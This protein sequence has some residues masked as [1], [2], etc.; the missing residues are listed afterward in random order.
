MRTTITI[1]DGL[2]DDAK[3]AAE[4]L[5]TTVSALVEEALR[6]RLAA[7]DEAPVD[8]PFRL[9]T[10]RGDGLQSGVTWGSLAEQADIDDLRVL[11]AADR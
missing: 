1:D 8:P 9:V 4:Q 2:L 3:R 6:A 11:L 10:F 7:R 5:G